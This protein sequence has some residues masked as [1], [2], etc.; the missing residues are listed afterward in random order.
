[1]IVIG[2]LNRSLLTVESAACII[3]VS[4]VTRDMRK[5]ECIRLKKS[6]DCRTIFEKSSLRMSVTTLL[7]THAM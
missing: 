2:C 1:M 6:I 4:F 7:L 5:P 3:R